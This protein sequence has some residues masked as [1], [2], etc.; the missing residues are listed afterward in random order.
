[1]PLSLPSQNEREHSSVGL[2]HLPYKQRVRGSSPCAPTE[3]PA[4]AGFFYC[5]YSAQ[6]GIGYHMREL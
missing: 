2:E 1:M 5:L 4:K 6:S 3:N